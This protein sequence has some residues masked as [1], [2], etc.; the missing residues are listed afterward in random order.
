MDL[1]QNAMAA[2]RQQ[3]EDA[4]EAGV[5]SRRFLA[6]H[7]GG[8]RANPLPLGGGG[9]S[10]LGVFPLES[11]SPEN[12]STFRAFEF[13]QGRRRV[14]NADERRPRR[15]DAAP[16]CP[17]ACGVET[18]ETTVARWTTARRQSPHEA[19]LRGEQHGLQRTWPPVLGDPERRCLA[20]EGSKSSKRQ[21]GGRGARLT[22]RHGFLPRRTSESKEKRRRFT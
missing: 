14:T 10:V 22:G 7:L 16:G 11:R 1:A 3:M 13:A 2:A 17:T 19:T 6:R 9:H 12:V 20:L 15:R 5:E 8:T 4:E 18:H 21:R